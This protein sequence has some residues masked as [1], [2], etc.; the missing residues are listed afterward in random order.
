M[1]AVKTSQILTALILNQKL[2]K[3]SPSLHHEY[4]LLYFKYGGSSG[5]L[6]LELSSFDIILA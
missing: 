1:G 3:N 4:V 6:S 2:Y 5:I